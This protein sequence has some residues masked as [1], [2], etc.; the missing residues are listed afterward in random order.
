MDYLNDAT[1]TKYIRNLLSFKEAISKVS[2]LYI[3]DFGIGSELRHRIYGINGIS[4]YIV[5]V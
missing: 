2:T 1:F 3:I 4:R 5:P